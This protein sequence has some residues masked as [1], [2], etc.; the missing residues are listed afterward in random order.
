MIK[1]YRGK[2]AMLFSS[3]MLLE[4]QGQ[5]TLQLNLISLENLFAKIKN[6]PE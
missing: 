1:G 5:S 4:L 6:H 2:S 3:E